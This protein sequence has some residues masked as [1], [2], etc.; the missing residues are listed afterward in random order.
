VT[1][2]AK[3]NKSYELSMNLKNDITDRAFRFQSLVGG[4]IVAYPV[5]RNLRE[6]NRLAVVIRCTDEDDAWGFYC[7]DVEFTLF[8]EEENLCRFKCNG[9]HRIA[10]CRILRDCDDIPGE[11]A[12]ISQELWADG[13]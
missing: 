5:L 10:A 7:N 12:R 1:K 6:K 3:Q 9:C 11:V 2:Q 13:Q 4:I 8:N